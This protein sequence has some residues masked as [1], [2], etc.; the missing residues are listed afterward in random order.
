MGANSSPPRASSQLEV[1]TH[2]I[3]SPHAPITSNH[4]QRDGSGVGIQTAFAQSTLSQIPQISFSHQPRFGTPISL[5][6]P[7]TMRCEN[8][9]QQPLPSLLVV[10]NGRAAT[11]TFLTAE[12]CS[13][14]P[15]FTSRVQFEVSTRAACS[16]RSNR[17]CNNLCSSPIMTAGEHG[18]KTSKSVHL[19]LCQP[20]GGHARIFAKRHKAQDRRDHLNCGLCAESKETE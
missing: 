12:P 16:T 20:G 13:P 10:D 15:P 8:S 1:S 6:Q 9:N 7:V 19:L 3:T 4:H 17:T 5:P 11:L 14:C 18:S 2:H